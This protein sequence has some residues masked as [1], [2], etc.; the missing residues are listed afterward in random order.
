MTY[1]V[2][3]AASRMATLIAALFA[4]GGVA[5]AQTTAA[6]RPLVLTVTDSTLVVPAGAVTA[7]VVT[8]QFVNRGRGVHLLQLMFVTT[9]RTAD[10]AKTYLL[11]NDR[12]PLPL[13]IG[14]GPLEG[15]QTITATVKLD[16]GTYLV[17]DSLPDAHGRPNFRAGIVGSVTL[18][19]TASRDVANIPAVSGLM[20][21]TR[22]R[23]GALLRSG[24]TWTQAEDRNRSTVVRQ[25]LQ[26]IR[27]ESFVSGTHSVVLARG[28][29]E[30]M[31]QYVEWKEGRRAAPPAGLVGGVTNIPGVS[32][33]PGRMAS[34]RVFLQAR[35]R[36]GGHILFCA[37][38][39]RTGL[40]G[41][42]TGEFTQF[43]VQ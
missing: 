8:I 28:G 22:F 26:T 18:G 29:P 38:L 21:A 2:R 39:D 19:G 30:V 40:R 37:D 7:G 9:G 11:T 4:W 42:E 35:L 12:P 6:A 36:A 34:N 20:I 23:F 14:V 27:I 13:T 33:Q 5:M 32:M 16:P 25:G 41:Y 1:V 17:Y 3:M 24:N 43:S 31:R 15:G 10:E